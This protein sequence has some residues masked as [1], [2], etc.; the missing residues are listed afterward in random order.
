LTSK[1]TNNLVS[2]SIWEIRWSN[3]FNSMLQ[4]NLLTMF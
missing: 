2:M 3:Q 4:L 1:K